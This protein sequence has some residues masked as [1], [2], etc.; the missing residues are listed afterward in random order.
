[1]GPITL[2]EIEEFWNDL[3]RAAD[4][5]DVIMLSPPQY[6]RMMKG[7]KEGEPITPED[8]KRAYYG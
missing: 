8:L 4:G 7:K 3:G 1:M 5:P 2:K 6:Q